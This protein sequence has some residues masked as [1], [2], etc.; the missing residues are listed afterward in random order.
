MLYLKK[1]EGVYT[2]NFHIRGENV[3]ITK[4]IRD[5]IETKIEKLE[6]Y[7]QSEVIKDVHIKVNVKKGQHKIEVTIP[8]SKWV[9]RAEEKTGDLYSSVDLVVDKLERQIRKHKT[10][11]NRKAREKEGLKHLLFVEEVYPTPLLPEKETE[12]EEEIK[13]VKTKRFEVKPMEVEEAI[14]QMNL[15][16][17]SFFYFKDAEDNAL[18]IVYARNDDTYGLIEFDNQ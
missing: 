8:M 9:L 5:H 16:G 1:S 17:H 15:V 14:L 4:A 7:F 18:K 10:R 13:I 11:V 6:K 3:E 12:Q 2:M